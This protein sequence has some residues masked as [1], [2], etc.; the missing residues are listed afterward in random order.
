MVRSQFTGE[1]LLSV[2]RKAIVEHFGFNHAS[3]TRIR[4]K[5]DSLTVEISRCLTPLFAPQLQT[6]II[7]LLNRIVN[8]S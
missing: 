6:I 2:L 5:N 4:K 3:K 8:L 7:R 1:K